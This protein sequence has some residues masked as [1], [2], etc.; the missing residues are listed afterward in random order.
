M[1]GEQPGVKK[2][3]V[4]MDWSEETYARLANLRE[5]G[6]LKDNAHVPRGSEA[7]QICSHAEQ[8]GIFVQGSDS[9]W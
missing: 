1:S 9:Q 6:G 8:K 2:I 5:L 7:L 3:R 4:T